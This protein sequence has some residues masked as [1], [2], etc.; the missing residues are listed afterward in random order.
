M[1]LM[2]LTSTNMFDLE[3]LE[4]TIIGKLQ[5]NIGNIIFAIIFIMFLFVIKYILQSEMKG[6]CPYCGR[7][8]MLRKR[9]HDKVCLVCKKEFRLRNMRIYKGEDI[10]DELLYYI[11]KAFACLAVMS[12]NIIEEQRKYVETFG[13]AQNITRRQFNDMNN[14]YERTLKTAK[15]MKFL[16]RGVVDKLRL[17]VE[18]YYSDRQMFEIENTENNLLNILYNFAMLDGKITPEEEKFFYYFKKLFNITGDRFNLVTSHTYEA[19]RT[20]RGYGEPRSGESRENI[21]ANNEYTYH[22][23]QHNTQETK[24]NAYNTKSKEYYKILECDSNISDDE[25]KKQYKKLMMQYHPDKYASNDLPE[26]IEKMLN[27]KMS[28]LNEAYEQIKKERGIN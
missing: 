25:L 26:E 27:N 7:E 19:P 1:Y 5:A 10:V 24:N 9:H 20:S 4:R 16:Y 11:T 14:I 13:I 17:Y 8:F 6:S 23:Q 18:D 22:T 15:N 12:G 28:E 2:D 21:E 3:L